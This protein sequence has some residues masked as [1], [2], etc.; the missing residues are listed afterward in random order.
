MLLGI[1]SVHG[2]GEE[3]NL[4]TALWDSATDLLPEVWEARFIKGVKD[5]NLDPNFYGAYI[6]QDAAWLIEVSKVYEQVAN[7]ESAHEA[8]REYATR[9]TA[10]FLKFGQELWEDFTVKEDATIIG[11][12]ATNYLNIVN[13]STTTYGAPYVMIAT[14]ACT[15]LWDN[16]TAELSTMVDSSNPYALWVYNNSGNSGRHAA[17]IDTWASEWYDLNL[18]IAI[19]RQAMGGEIGLF[20]L[21]PTSNHTTL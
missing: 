3:K 13:S 12:A 2:F 6:M 10:S 18:S 16:I 8:L 19:F 15:I 21:W 17:F 5:G 14:Y 7:D 9:R 1:N 11:T 20:N 4:S